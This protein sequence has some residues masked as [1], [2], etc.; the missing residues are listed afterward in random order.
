MRI[1]IEDDYFLGALV[2]TCIAAVVISGF[3][4]C[5]LYCMASLEH[6]APVHAEAAK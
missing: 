4:M 1:E 2:I 5:H 6:P 3:F